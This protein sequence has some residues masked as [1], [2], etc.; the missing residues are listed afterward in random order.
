MNP[1]DRLR[2]ARDHRNRYAITNAGREVGAL[3][4]ALHGGP[5]LTL[6]ANELRVRAYGRREL[7]LTD[8][9]TGETVAVLKGDDLVAGRGEFR[10]NKLPFKRRARLEQDGRTIATFARI[11]DG[12]RRELRAEVHET[13]PEPHLLALAAAL[14]TAKGTF[15]PPKESDA[16][17]ERVGAWDTGGARRG[18]AKV[19]DLRERSPWLRST[20]R[21]ESGMSPTEVSLGAGN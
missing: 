16:T 6:G 9:E 3:R 2:V 7:K 10:L 14:L 4:R 21:D 15:R 13:P 11:A 5:R 8:E 17:G 12:R 18:L 19:G 1:G 20:G